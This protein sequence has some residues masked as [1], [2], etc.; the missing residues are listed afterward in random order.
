[1]KLAPF[2]GPR[3]AI[4]GFLEIVDDLVGFVAPVFA[5]DQGAT[6]IGAVQHDD[7]LCKYRKDMILHILA[8]TCAYIYYN[9]NTYVYRLDIYWLILFVLQFYSISTIANS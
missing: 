9:Y 6:K 7:S 3:C 4:I 5:Q 8:C 2:T 1:M